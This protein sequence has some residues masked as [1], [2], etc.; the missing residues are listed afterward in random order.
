MVKKSEDF[1]R[2]NTLKYFE[3]L[4]LSLTQRLRKMAILGQ[5][6]EGSQ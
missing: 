3:A 6:P 4:N 1:N 5:L 2:E